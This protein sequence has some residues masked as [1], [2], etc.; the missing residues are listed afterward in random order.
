[1]KAGHQLATRFREVILNGYWIANTNLKNELSSLYWE[2]AVSKLPLLNT[3]SDLVQHLH[4][5]LK[6]IKNVFT[7]G[8]LEIKDKYSFD[9]PPI[10]SQDEWNNLLGFFWGLK[11]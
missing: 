4:Y 5:Y 9:F 11:C 7:G 6:G 3:I 8:E 1:M 2:T 10:R